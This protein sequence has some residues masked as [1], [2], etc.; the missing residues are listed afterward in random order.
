M[1]K[2]G[3]YTKFFALAAAASFLS[4]GSTVHAAPGTASLDSSEG[5][6]TGASAGDSL[7]AGSVISTQAGGRAGIVVNGNRITIEPNTTLTI[8]ILE[9]EDTGVEKVSKVQLSLQAG[10]IRGEVQKFSSLSSFVVKLP[11]G[12][13]SIDATGGNVTFDI[14]ADGTVYIPTGVADIVF[15]RGTAQNNIV[16]FQLNGQGFNPVSGAPIDIPEGITEGITRSVQGFVVP[17]TVTPT[18]PVQPFQFFVS[19]NLGKQAS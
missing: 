4:L 11:K 3:V 14:S 2:S 6:V 19:P 10:R 13:V 12:Q 7:G 17:P 16:A 8:D 15:D 18:Q 1:K 5:A 9:E